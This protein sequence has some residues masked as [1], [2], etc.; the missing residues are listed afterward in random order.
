M[1]KLFLHCREW[2]ADRSGFQ[3]P[4]PR[5]RPAVIE[6]VHEFRFSDF[7]IVVKSLTL[8]GVCLLIAIPMLALCGL[9]IYA[10]FVGLVRH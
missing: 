3:Y 6:P 9:L 7:V 2:L 8:A 5:L 10:L 4:R 1:K